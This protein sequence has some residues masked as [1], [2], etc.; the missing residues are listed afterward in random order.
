MRES[1]RTRTSDGTRRTF[2]RGAIGVSLVGLAGCTG[3]DG[4]GVEA[5]TDG[6]AGGTTAVG[7]TA[8]VEERPEGVSAEEFVSGPVPEPYRTA[9]SQGGETRD[10]SNLRTK[11]AVQFQE[12]SDA[13]AAGL[14]RQGNSCENC[15]EFIPDQD[16]DG[17]GACAKVEGYVASE[18]W[19]VL[20]E[21]MGEE[22][23]G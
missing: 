3:G 9:T 20:W 14:A 2:V 13:V 15:A 6:G 22:E 7:G 11:A 5:T 8:G 23:T 18:D 10:P 4:S 17:F 12:A 16:G 21:A 1:K 19:C